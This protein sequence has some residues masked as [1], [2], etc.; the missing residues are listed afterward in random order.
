[1]PILRNSLSDHGVYLKKNQTSFCEEYKPNDEKTFR[2]LHFSLMD[3]S[4]IK[5]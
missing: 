4:Y 5:L 3:Y 1:M 2:K